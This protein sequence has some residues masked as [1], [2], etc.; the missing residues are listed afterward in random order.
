MD[1]YVTRCPECQ[2]A[3]R[4]TPAQLAAADGKVRCG[5]CLTVFNATDNGPEDTIRARMA[6]L[7]LT[8]EQDEPKFGA[9]NLES[10]H[11]VRDTVELELPQAKARRAKQLLQA[12]AALI[13]I[14]ALL[15][16]YLWHN[17]LVLAQDPDRRAWAELLCSVLPCE[18]PPLHDMSAF[19][20]N[21]LV[22]RSHPEQ[23]DQLQ[24][25][26]TVGNTARFAQPFPSIEVVF[27]DT[28][29]RRVAQRLIT[30]TEYLSDE[31]Q[32]VTFMP[33]DSTIQIQVDL[34][35]PG[36]QAVNYDVT[37]APSF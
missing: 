2:T 26:L 17:R 27:R 10:L 33:A 29:Q 11:R 36:D 4:M 30:P 14:A 28:D 20:G 32:A 37:L 24:L 6:E 23:L 34:D 9:D 5:A 31:L 7:D 35:D 12:T 1:F 3:F 22:I 21:S 19:S 16:Q 25:T 13:L 8:E 15:L 18:L